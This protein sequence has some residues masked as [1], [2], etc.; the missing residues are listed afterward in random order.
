MMTIKPVSALLLFLFLL[1]TLKS[2]AQ[3]NDKPP[4]PLTVSSEQTKLIDEI[5]T[6]LGFKAYYT[7]YC[8]DVID[9]VA[10]TKKWSASKIKIKKNKVNFADF[11]FIA[12]NSY[13][14]L[15]VENLKTILNLLKK[16]NLDI[17]DYFWGSYLIIDN[18][19]VFANH[20]LEN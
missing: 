6:V 13:A 5:I 12:R 19:K 1:N 8:K 16:V 3:N 10:V 14:G 4:Q 18:L 9:D 17:A 7:K 15:K 20:Y 2:G 11:E